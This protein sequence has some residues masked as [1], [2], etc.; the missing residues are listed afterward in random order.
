MHRK[1]S[2]KFELI[3]GI[4]IISIFVLETA[5]YAHYNQLLGIA[6][7]LSLKADGEVVITN[8]V[9]NSATNA[10]ETAT[11]IYSNRDINLF[12]EFNVTTLENT[13]EI[14]YNITIANNTHYDYVFTNNDFNYSITVQ[15]DSSLDVYLDG[16][17]IGD[18]IPKMSE[19]TFSVTIRLNPN[20]ENTDYDVN[21]NGDVDI[22]VND[23]ASLLVAI[24]T[25]EGDLSGSNTLAHFEFDALNGFDYSK[26][27]NLYIN[28]SLFELCDRF[29][30][31]LSTFTI[32]ASDNSSVFDFY[33]KKIATDFSTD[34]EKLTVMYSYDT[35]QSV[36]GTL[37]IKVDKTIINDTTAPVI[38]NVKATQNS[39]VNSVHL[40][41]RGY[42]ESSIDHYVIQVFKSNGTKVGNDYTTIGNETFIDVAVSSGT[43]NNDGEYYFKVY[44]IDRLSNTASNSEIANATVSAGHCSRSAT[45]KF[46]WYAKVSYT[47]SFTSGSV[48]E[49]L[50]GSNLSTTI[51][52]QTLNRPNL[53]Y[54]TMNGVRLN[55]NQ[56]TTS[57]TNN[58]T[59]KINNVTGDIV[60]DTNGQCLIE[61]TKI[62]LADGTY[63]NIEDI[64]YYDLL[65]VWSYDTGKLTYE[66][67]IWIEEEHVTD[68]YQLNVFSDG[69]ILKTL[70]YHGIYNYDLN[71]FVS[72]D[73]INEFYVG[74]TVAKIENGQLKKVTVTDIK[75]VNET[76]KYYHVVSS[77]YYNIIANDILTTDGTVILSNIIDFDDNIKWV[78]KDN[79]SKYSY[80]YFSDIVPY[81]MYY[82]MRMEDAVYLN[83]FNFDLNKFKLYLKENQLNETL[84]KPLN[85]NGDLI[86][87]ISTSDGISEYVKEN[88]LF[89]IPGNDNIYLNTLD[90]KI[91]KSNDILKVVYSS[92]LIK[93]K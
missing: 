93:I 34:V 60:I 88:Y 8:V 65:A 38:S 61:E 67:P 25:R 90:N 1:I 74:S 41:W 33:V 27:F 32:D 26:I 80:S 15:D 17:A 22:D 53:N 9:L 70:G 79:V 14:S 56:Y 36:A 81:Y 58:L 45:T 10:I 29:G 73:D 50:I 23:D 47:G 40:T 18:A 87:K 82:G 24:R 63:K 30:N 76:V 55:S 16:I 62:L 66:Y 7:D 68:S 42:D 51:S 83:K 64:G 28:S 57:G 89:V 2:T 19:I 37:N 77:R 4:L 39:K 12:N 21:L 5:G 35:Y 75:I 49:V 13:Y 71:K 6:V 20:S 31:P 54:I 52:G 44:G 11:P 86:F 72:V 84:Y 85:S 46:K 78:N 91:Y 59:I 48:S 92:H 69:T 43:S 3:I